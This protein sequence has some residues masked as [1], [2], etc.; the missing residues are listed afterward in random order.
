MLT[1]DVGTVHNFTEKY[2]ISIIFKMNEYAVLYV[3]NNSA[4]GVGSE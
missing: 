1:T 4:N 2:N 3:I